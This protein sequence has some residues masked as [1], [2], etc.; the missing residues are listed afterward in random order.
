M[1][2]LRLESE[3]L[4]IRRTHSQKQGELSVLLA[5]VQRLLHEQENF[6]AK[7]RRETFDKLSQA[8]ANLAVLTQQLVQI[9]KSVANIT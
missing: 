4:E 9:K 6:V 3:T 1:D 7:T 5:Q 2:L 8:Q